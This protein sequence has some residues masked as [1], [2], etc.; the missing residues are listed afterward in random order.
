V[1][2]AHLPSLPVGF[3]AGGLSVASIVGAVFFLKFWRR[4]RDSLFLAFAA[5]FVL[6]A[7][8][9]AGPV[10]LGIPS[11][12]ASKMYLFRAAAFLLIIFAILRKNFARRG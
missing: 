10:L 4:T 6:M 7:V 2:L 3:M 1:N 9:Q 5:A 12:E 8:N 11:E